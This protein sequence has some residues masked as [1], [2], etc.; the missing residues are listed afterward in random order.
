MEDTVTG[1]EGAIFGAGSAF[2]NQLALNDFRACVLTACF[3]VQVW[4]DIA[5]YKVAM[6]CGTCVK[7]GSGDLAV[8]INQNLPGHLRFAWPIVET[9]DRRV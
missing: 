8:T 9:T 6:V 2:G 7:V 5:V 4:P 1:G 3:A